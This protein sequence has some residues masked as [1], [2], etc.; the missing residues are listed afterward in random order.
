LVMRGMIL[1]A[2]SHI[3]GFILFSPLLKR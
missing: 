3:E 1:R 2:C